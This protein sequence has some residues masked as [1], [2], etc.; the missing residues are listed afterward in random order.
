MDAHLLWSFS[1]FFINIELMNAIP[2]ASPA[3]ETFGASFVVSMA[4]FSIMAPIS[5]NLLS[6]LRF[7]D[8]IRWREE[9][10]K[11]SAFPDHFNAGKTFN[12]W[13]PYFPNEVNNRLITPL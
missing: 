10:P 8:S 13:I 6:N 4:K 7:V 5:L 11:Q 9:L 1:A 2:D 12:G 3:A